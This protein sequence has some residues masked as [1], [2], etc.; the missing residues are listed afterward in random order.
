MMAPYSHSCFIYKPQIARG[1]GTI[2]LNFQG[3]HDFP[4]SEKY[5]INFWCYLNRFYLS[6]LSVLN[7]EKFRL[8]VRFF[9]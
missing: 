6:D 8:N 9:T 7:G 3:K 5:E 1:R 2:F 4:D